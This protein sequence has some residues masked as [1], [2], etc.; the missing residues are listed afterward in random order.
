MKVQSKV[1]AV[2]AGAAKSWTVWLNTIFIGLALMEAA[3]AHLTELFGENAS[4]K[5]VAIGAIANL[6]LRVKT[7]QSLL[8]KGS[9]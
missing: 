4:A 7:T 2:W 1:Q 5:L 3:G 8:A 9:E 6:L